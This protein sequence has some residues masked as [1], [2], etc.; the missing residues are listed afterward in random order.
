MRC[1]FLAV[2]LV[3]LA[4]AAGCTPAPP[5]Q[6]DEKDRLAQ[7]EKDFDPLAQDREKPIVIQE[8]SP[9]AQA[10]ETPQE[11]QQVAPPADISLGPARPGL[12]QGYRVQIFL[13]DDLREAARVMAE[14]RESFQEEVYL[15]YD[16]PYYKVRVGDCRTEGEGQQLL[17]VAH[18]L[19]YRDAW[20]MYTV[21]SV[22]E[23]PEEQ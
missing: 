19:G 10:L 5:M 4:L 22:A 21:I 23:E 9:E 18:R 15:E 20:L 11:D 12:I 3:L 1:E 14:A 6:E 7:A 13:S 8:A 2:F 16:A 17:E